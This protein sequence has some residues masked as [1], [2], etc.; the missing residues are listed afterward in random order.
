VY[1]ATLTRKESDLLLGA[2]YSRECVQLG[3]DLWETLL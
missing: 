2:V 1:T 3:T